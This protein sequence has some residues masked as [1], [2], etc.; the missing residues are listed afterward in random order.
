MAKKELPK[1]RKLGGGS[2]RI[3]GKIIKPNQVFE[4]DRTF[5]E[6]IL[7]HLEPMNKA[8]SEIKETNGESF[9]FKKKEPEPTNEP[10]NEDTQKPEDSKKGEQDE[11]REKKEAPGTGG[12]YK[13][14]SSKGWW[15]VFNSEGKQQNE[16]ALRETKADELIEILAED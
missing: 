6:L 5:S 12:F 4:S 9:V 2:L 14:E 7:M 8:A 11:S 13:E 15:N 3:D 1:W 10:E 16:K